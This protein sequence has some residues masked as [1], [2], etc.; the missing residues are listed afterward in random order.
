M[1]INQSSDIKQIFR[2]HH[3]I[4]VFLSSRVDEEKRSEG[5]KFVSF[6]ETMSKQLTFHWG[7]EE[8]FTET[9]KE[10]L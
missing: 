7:K 5:G 1:N 2:F 8:N 3:N 4:S 6:G 10:R 9:K